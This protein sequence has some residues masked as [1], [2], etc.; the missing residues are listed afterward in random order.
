MIEEVSIQIRVPCT[1]P[2]R[3]LVKLTRR[4]HDS[5]GKPPEITAIVQ[6]PQIQ[7]YIICV[8]YPTPKLKG[9]YAKICEARQ[10]VGDKHGTFSGN[11]LGTP[12]FQ[13]F[14]KHHSVLPLWNSKQLTDVEG[15]DDEGTCNISGGHPKRQNTECEDDT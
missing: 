2:P 4:Q 11:F 9:R 8:V 3:L 6:C 5:V 1:I 14:H 7:V 10:F 13:T 12:R 15:K